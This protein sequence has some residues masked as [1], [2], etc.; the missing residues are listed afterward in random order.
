MKNFC[1]GKNSVVI[2]QAVIRINDVLEG[3]KSTIKD[4]SEKNKELV[5]QNA[6][7]KAR[8]EE[9]ESEMTQMKL[10]TAKK[11]SV[12]RRGSKRKSGKIVDFKSD[13]LKC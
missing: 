8:V 6:W 5:E 9:V 10:K 1:R 12:T 3:Q 7:L 11:G 4:L 13:S 2:D